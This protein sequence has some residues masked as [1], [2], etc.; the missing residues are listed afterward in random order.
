MGSIFQL[1]N[2]KWRGVVYTEKVNGKWKRKYVQGDSEKEVKRKVNDIEYELQHNLYRDPGRV[3]METFLNEW[4]EI[5]KNFIEENTAE[6]Y[7]NML[8][9]HIIPGIG[10]ILLRDLK[11]Q[12]LDE[13][14][15]NLHNKPRKPLHDKEKVV[16]LSW[17]SIKKINSIISESLKYAMKNNKILTNAA[18]LT[19]LPKKE[20][21]T[22]EIMTEK[23]FN[24]LLSNVKGTFDEIPILLAACTGLRRGEVFGLRWKDID[25]KNGVIRVKKVVTRY[26]KYVTKKPKNE[27]SQRFFAVP[28]FVMD[29][30]ENYRKSLKVIPEKVCNE[31]TAQSYS[32]HFKLLLEK[33]NLPHVRFHDLRHF[34]TIIMLK[35]GVKDKVASKR[36]GHASTKTTKDIYQHVLSD[37]DLEAARIINDVFDRPHITTTHQTS[38]HTQT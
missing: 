23:N 29:I 34:N 2:G 15:N 16:P 14:Y 25:F 31:F 28:R 24:T 21:Y 10:N 8:D 26:K 13:F 18:A 3:K 22:P 37:M 12:D 1:K 4:F 17:N 38:Q 30:L 6:Y 27:T 32:K 36:L 9:K 5:Q 35:Y 7:R 33:F 19:S 20:K 11:P